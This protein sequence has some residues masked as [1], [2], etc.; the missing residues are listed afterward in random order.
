MSQ[1]LRVRYLYAEST[2]PVLSFTSMCQLKG[3]TLKPSNLAIVPPLWRE[4]LYQAAT[5]VNAKLL[6]QLNQ[7]TP[8]E[9]KYLANALTE[10]TRQFRFDLIVDLTQSKNE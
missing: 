3:D 10:L 1:Y 4:Q 5:R 2:T 8:L 7:K 9:N 6:V